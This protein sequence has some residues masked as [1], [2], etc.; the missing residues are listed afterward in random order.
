MAVWETWL[1]HNALDALA[2]Y[3]VSKL[4]LAKSVWSACAGAAAGYVATA[5]RLGWT[6]VDARNVINDLGYPIDFVCTP[7]TVVIRE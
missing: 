2:D 3:A 5:Q 1:P 4:V 6:I 7:R